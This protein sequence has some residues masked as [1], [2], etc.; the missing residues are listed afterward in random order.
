MTPEDSSTLDR[1]SQLEKKVNALERLLQVAPGITGSAAVQAAPRPAPSVP[2]AASQRKPAGE[3]SSSNLLAGIGIAFVVLASVFFIKMTIDA[4]WL[5]PVRQVAIGT[6]FGLVLCVLPRFI[7]SLQDDYGARLAGG[8]IAVLH[9]TW[10]GG[11]SIHGVVSAQAALAAASA[12]GLVGILLPPTPKESGT[13]ES[14]AYVVLAIAGTYLSAPLIGVRTNEPYLILGLLTVWNLGFCAL[15]LLKQDRNLISFAGFFAVLATGILATNGVLSA[16]DMS[17]AITLQLLG[18]LVIFAG[19]HAWLSRSS[20]MSSREAWFLVPT[21]LLHYG[22]LYG[23]ISRWEPS[24]A[25]WMGLGA[26]AFCFGIF[27]ATRRH[28]GGKLESS[29]AILT[30]ISL[31]VFHSGFIELI[32]DRHWG[33]AAALLWSLVLL[34]PANFTKNSS[35]L[36]RGPGAVLGLAVLFGMVAALSN[37]DPYV[38]V[39]NLAFGVIAIAAVLRV[40]G[41]AAPAKGRDLSSWILAVGHL[42]FLLGV[43][44]LSEKIDLPGSLFVSVLWGLYAIAVLGLAWSKRSKIVAHSATLILAATA[45][46]AVI[47]DVLNTT[48]LVRVFCLLAAGAVLYVCGRLY[49]ETKNWT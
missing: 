45:L 36:W 25:P 10:F 29:A 41:H 40:A 21:L 42:Q 11:Y 16:R 18:I 49:R 35:D 30:A 47:Y 34:V 48:A 19:S 5:T 3:D 46:K 23:V 15:G 12:V 13:S 1:L 27:E 6:L 33:W 39:N 26:S 20:P 31:M 28:L 43:Y 4:G 44:R 14:H 38:H 32:P 24:I 17:P 8:G 9:L 22:T 37:R 7:P 2:I